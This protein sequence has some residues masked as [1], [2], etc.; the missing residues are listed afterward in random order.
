MREDYLRTTFDMFDTNGNG[1]LDNDE[2]V[3]LLQG[4]SIQHIIDKETIKQAIAEIDTNGDGVIDF[5]EF[6]AMMDKGNNE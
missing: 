3:Q 1:V 5:E 2:I 6:K 4:D